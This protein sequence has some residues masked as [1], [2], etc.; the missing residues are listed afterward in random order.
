MTGQGATSTRQLRCQGL[1]YAR[2]LASGEGQQRCRSQ[3]VLEFCDI[4]PND[5]TLLLCFMNPGAGSPRNPVDADS[6]PTVAH[7]CQIPSLACWLPTIPD[8]THAQTVLLM[9]ALDCWRAVVVN[10][11]DVCEPKSEVLCQRVD[12]LKNN[13]PRWDSLFHTSRQAEL[14][15]LR[16]TNPHVATIG[17]WGA[18]SPKHKC[19]RDVASEVWRLFPSIA[20]WPATSSHP[21]GLSHPRP[22]A[23]GGPKWRY[24]GLWRKVV[25]SKRNLSQQAQDALSAKRAIDLLVDKDRIWIPVES[26]KLTIDLALADSPEGD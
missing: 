11:S 24:Y 5:R 6:I 17:G 19:L 14:N 9:E 21:L 18:L 4:E 15:N 3:L 8:A 16:A 26:D 20:G 25:A 12:A 22:T 23:Q 13:T 1:F 2:A 10:L 7:A